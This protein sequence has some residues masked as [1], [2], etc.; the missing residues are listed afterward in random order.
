MLLVGAITTTQAVSLEQM[1]SN[2]VQSV[3]AQATHQHVAVDK[4]AAATNQAT[5]KEAKKTVKES[6]PDSSEKLQTKEK[7]EKSLVV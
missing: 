6:R 2:S 3:N 5:K 7:S 1:N 4:K